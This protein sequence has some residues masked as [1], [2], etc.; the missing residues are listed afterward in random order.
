MGAGS[1][2]SLGLRGGESEWSLSHTNPSSYT[3]VSI[4][5]GIYAVFHKKRV[6]YKQIQSMKTNSS[7]YNEIFN[8]NSPYKNRFHEKEFNV[9]MNLMVL[10]GPS[11]SPQTSTNQPVECSRGKTLSQSS[12]LAFCLPS[13]VNSS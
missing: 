11:H 8:E 4:A 10:K 13:V 12:F 3:I 6:N 2:V 1:T 5:F 7:R 9:F